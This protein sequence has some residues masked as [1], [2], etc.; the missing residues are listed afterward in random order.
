MRRRIAAIAMVLVP[1]SPSIGQAQQTK[2]IGLS[3]Q[4]DRADPT[5]ALGEQL[6]LVIRVAMK[7][8]IEI[9]QVSPTNGLEKIAP[10]AGVLK[11]T[12]DRPLVLPLAGMNFRLK[13]P[14][15]QF[16]L[17]IIARV[18]SE[19]SRYLGSAASRIAG[20]ETREDVR[21]VYRVVNP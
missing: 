12:P 17:R 15:G 11:A 1:I 5:Y 18:G 9:W 20:R 7:A 6:G 10:V 19:T 3:A 21:L 8:E 13:R 4:F 16:E 2:A 14:L